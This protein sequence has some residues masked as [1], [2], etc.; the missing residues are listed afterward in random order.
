[1]GT[2][3][4][5]RP[6]VLP[7]SPLDMD[8]NV[9][10]NTDFPIHSLSSVGGMEQ[11]VSGPLRRCSEGDYSSSVDTLMLLDKWYLPHPCTLR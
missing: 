9:A 10:D 11:G 7:L 1:M 2:A 8:V 3:Q 5:S 6:N 4:W